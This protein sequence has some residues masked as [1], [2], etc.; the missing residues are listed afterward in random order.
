M[1]RPY[2]AI[3]LRENESCEAMDVIRGVLGLSG[4][5]A[6]CQGCA[7]K[8]LVRAGKKQGEELTDDFKKA[9]DY[10]FE[11]VNAIENANPMYWKDEPQP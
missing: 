2:Y 8:Y 1:E 11:A 10:L 3:P 9:R 4:F 6:F 7:I 5:V